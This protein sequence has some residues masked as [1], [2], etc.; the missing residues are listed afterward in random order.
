MHL[1]NMYNEWVRPGNFHLSQAG[2]NE[3]IGIG[4]SVWG[5]SSDSI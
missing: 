4:F 1:K 3:L 5:D 2:E